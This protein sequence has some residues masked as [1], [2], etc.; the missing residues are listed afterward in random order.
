MKLEP[1]DYEIIQTALAVLIINYRRRISD[2][3]DPALIKAH[4][5]CLTRITKVAIKFKEEVNANKP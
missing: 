1:E 4:R 2:E 5:N 3:D